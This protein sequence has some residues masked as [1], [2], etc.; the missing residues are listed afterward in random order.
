MN[1]LPGYVQPELVNEPRL[2]DI[3]DPDMEVF[4][5]LPE[6][7]RKKILS[8][9]NYQGSKLQQIIGATGEST[10]TPQEASEPAKA[11]SSAPAS[12]SKPPAPPVPPAPPA[13]PV[14][15]A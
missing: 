8:N 11:S 6:W 9:L 12:P 14:D 15:A 5:L 1:N 4:K 13:P 3:D 2:F 10:T 7:L